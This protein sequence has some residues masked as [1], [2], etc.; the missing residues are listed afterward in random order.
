MQWQV[1]VRKDV[2]KGQWNETFQAMVYWESFYVIAWKQGQAYVHT[3]HF[4]DDYDLANKLV[5]RIRQHP[6][7]T[8]ENKPMWVKITDVRPVKR[9]RSYRPTTHKGEKP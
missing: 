4:A 7:F 5:K 2:V 3:Y 8:P 9:T 1:T 6:C